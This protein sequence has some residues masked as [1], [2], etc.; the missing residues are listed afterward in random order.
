M[1]LVRACLCIISRRTISAGVT[2]AHG[3]GFVDDRPVAKAP[4][5]CAPRILIAAPVPTV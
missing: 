4:V 2:V 3:H 1:L 5:S